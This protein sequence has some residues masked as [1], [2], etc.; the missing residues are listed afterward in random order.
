MLLVCETKG[1]GVPHTSLS[2]GSELSPGMAVEPETSVPGVQVVVERMEEHSRL[3]SCVDEA[4]GEDLGLDAHL[5]RLADSL[6]RHVQ[7][8]LDR[9]VAAGLR[10]DDIEDM[11]TLV[12]YI[13]S[14]AA[15][16]PDSTADPAQRCR[17]RGVGMA[18][19]G[20]VVAEWLGLSSS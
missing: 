14:A 5:T 3:C 11:G 20:D 4:V 17:V 15:L 7:G 12:T 2:R 9:S 18:V 16:Q 8:L 10:V 13:R 19:A 6:E 1:E